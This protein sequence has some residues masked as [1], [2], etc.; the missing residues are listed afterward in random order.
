M[1]HPGITIEF[2]AVLF[3]PLDRLSREGVLETLRYLRT[4]TFYGAG[5]KSYTGC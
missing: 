5:W 4:L 1:Q 3:W 2:D